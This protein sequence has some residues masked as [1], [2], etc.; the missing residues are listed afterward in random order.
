VA[1]SISS[2]PVE[3]VTKRSA[4]PVAGKHH[5]RETASVRRVGQH[6]RDDPVQLKRLGW[7]AQGVDDGIPQ[8]AFGCVFG[9]HCGPALSELVVMGGQ[10]LCWCRRGLCGFSTGEVAAFD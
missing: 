7:V 9:H 3:W 10:L 4:N 5:A 2:H 6:M 8:P 1:I